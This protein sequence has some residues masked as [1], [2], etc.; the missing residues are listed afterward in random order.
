MKPTKYPAKGK[1]RGKKSE[2]SGEERKQKVKVK[3]AVSLL[4][5]TTTSKFCFLHM[6][7][8]CK[9]IFGI[10]IRRPRSVRLLNDFTVSFSSL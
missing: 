9:L 1:G 5:T 10:W 2:K 7:K 3:T 8:L 4:N 6:P